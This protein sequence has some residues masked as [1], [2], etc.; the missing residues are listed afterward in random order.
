MK[1]KPKEKEASIFIAPP[2][3]KQAAFTIRGTSPLVSHQMSQKTRIMMREK[4]EQGD[5][6]VR[7]KKVRKPRDF[8]SDFGGSQH[9][10]TKGWVG[11]PV[12][13]FKN[14]MVAACRTTG[15]KMTHMKMAFWVESEGFSEFGTGLIPIEKREPY[16][17]IHPAPVSNG[18]W[19]LRV[20]AM[21]DPGWQ[22]VVRLRYDADMI[23]VES[24]GNL[25]MRAGLQVGVLEGRNFSKMSCGMGWGFFEVLSKKEGK[26]HEAA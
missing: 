22:A 6:K 16:M 1:S 10:S 20:R 24:L 4:M 21:F 18:N 2:N 14:A 3:L 7:G 5:L 15:D 12:M 17:C 11:I 26:K 25:L 19:D 8:E 23:S 13:A 9:I